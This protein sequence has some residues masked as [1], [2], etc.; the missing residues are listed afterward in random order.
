MDIEQSNDLIDGNVHNHN[1]ITIVHVIT[2]IKRGGAEN[3]LLVL[4]REQVRKGYKVLVV[5]LKED[6]EL[7][8]EFEKSNIE[9]DEF[10]HNLNFLRQVVKL[11]SRYRACE[12]IVH[13]HLP[14]AELAVFFSGIKSYIVTRH[15]GD[16]FYPFRNR[17]ISN[18]LSRLATRNAYAVI[19]ISNYV[20]DY[21]LN[22]GE[23]SHSKNL[24]TIYYG[25]ENSRIRN[26]KYELENS[27]EI[28]EN[29]KLGTLSRLSKEKDLETLIKGIRQYLNQ[30]GNQHITLQ[31]FGRG[32]EKDNLKNLIKTLNLENN[33]KIQ[34]FTPRP[35]E[36]IASFDLFILTSKYE[37]FGLVLL[38]AMSVGT[39][40]VCSDIPTAR[41]VLGESG[42]YFEVGNET[43]L[44]EKIKIIVSDLRKYSESGKIRSAKFS[45]KKSAA[46]IESVYR[47]ALRWRKL[48][49]A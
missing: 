2:T 25:I 36:T 24:I 19:A 47:G 41:E 40:V 23:I 22:S 16:K 15:Y 18:L 46:E 10:T 34:D 14:Q 6:L 33:I 27:H 3:Q 8:S 21:L 42:V 26:M 11:R 28:N 35:L 45:V 1:G 5:P 37:G 20:R 32:P 48:N 44:A 30:N 17:Y 31:I 43:D 49:D 7:K 12:Y 38:E 29:L 9:I 13:A 39:P 4:C